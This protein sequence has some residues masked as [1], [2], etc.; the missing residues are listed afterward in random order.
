MMRRSLNTGHVRAKPFETFKDSV[1]T[2]LP[3]SMLG[4]K[5]TLSPKPQLSVL[6]QD[7]SRNFDRAKAAQTFPPNQKGQIVELDTFVLPDAVT[8]CAS[9]VALGKQLIKAW[10]KEGIL[11]IEFPAELKVLSDAIKASKAFFA[12]PPAAKEKCVDSQSFA[13]YIASGEEITD[14]IAD[15][16]EIFTCT[17]DL[18]VTDRRVKE[19]WPCHGPTPWPSDS[20]AKAISKLMEYKGVVGEK[21]L[22]LVGLGL[23]LKDP[24]ALCKLASDGWHHMRV[25]RFVEPTLLLHITNRLEDFLPRPALMAEASLAAA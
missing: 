4:K 24:D 25:L 1:N 5:P 16:S 3:A 10:R 15:Y 2:S 9:D 21:L 12:M 19:A 23:G 14:G 7:P 22:K 13:G 8:G 17:K 20:Y 6:E 18:P 11:Q